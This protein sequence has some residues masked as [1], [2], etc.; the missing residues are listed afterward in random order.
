[1]DKLKTTYLAP[2][3]SIEMLSPS[4]YILAASPTA[5]DSLSDFGEVTPDWTID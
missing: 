5:S 3:V 2:S 1:M 4:M